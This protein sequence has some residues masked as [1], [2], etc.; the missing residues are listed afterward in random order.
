MEASLARCARK[1]GL[2][3]VP[4]IMYST[5]AAHCDPPPETGL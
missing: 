3:V 4:K 2:S 5:D 1:S